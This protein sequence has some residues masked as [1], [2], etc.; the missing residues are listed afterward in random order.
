MSS[1]AGNNWPTITSLKTG[2]WETAFQDSILLPSVLLT[3]DA[4]DYAQIIVDVLAKDAAGYP[5]TVVDV[6]GRLLSYQLLYGTDGGVTDT[7]SGITSNSNFTSHSVPYPIIA[8]LGVATYD[9]LTYPTNNSTQY[10]LHP[11][12]FGSW[13]KG[14]A[15][16]TQTKYLGSNLTDGEPTV[17]GVCEINYDNLG[18]VLGTSSDIFDAIGEV[19]SP[20]SSSTAEL[21]PF[22]ESIV[23]E[24][25]TATLRD[26]YATYPNPFY[27]YA[28][29]TLVSGQAELDLADGGESNENN[30]IWCVYRPTGGGT[31]ATIDRN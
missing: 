28:A 21:G 7:L 17:S 25:H 14:V 9:G 10:E 26:L 5:I 11:Y 3:S 6:Y 27:G 23:T 8:S 4:T 13:D 30:P 1:F 20:D 22:L 29:S 15:A 24:A 12:E 31:P 19:I 2:L 16:F 18:Y